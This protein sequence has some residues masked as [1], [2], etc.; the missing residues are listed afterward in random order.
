MRSH[1]ERT[2]LIDENS[3]ITENPSA[4]VNRRVEEPH[5]RLIRHLSVVSASVYLARDLGEVR[6]WKEKQARKAFPTRLGSW[7]LGGRGKS[8]F[9]VDFTD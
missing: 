5:R 8:R 9:Y 7:E 1:G 4:L 3:I 6:W 2:T